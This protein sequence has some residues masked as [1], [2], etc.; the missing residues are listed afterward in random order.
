MNTTAPR[1]V[2]PARPAAPTV[3]D[4]QPPTLLEGALRRLQA[5][6]CGLHGHDSL[7]QFE[8][9]RLYLRCSSCG[10]E[11]PGWELS[12]SGYEAPRHEAR[13]TRV[14]ADLHVVRRIA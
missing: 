8:R 7:L 5:F 2:H 12:S 3:K 14:P 13:P 1:H 10:F 9:H 4:A 6:L 11:T